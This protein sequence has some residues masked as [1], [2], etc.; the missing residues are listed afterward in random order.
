MDNNELI[1]CYNKGCGQKFKEE[2]NNDEVCK[3][4][5]GVPVFH[6]ALKGWSCCKKR[7]T[8]FTDFL[9]IPGCTTGPHNPVKPP[10]AEKSAIAP[11]KEGES[12]IVK[13]PPPPRARQK[14]I[15]ARPADDEPMV[16]LKTKVTSSLSSLLTR[17]ARQATVE[18]TKNDKENTSKESCD[19]ETVDIG[20]N[21]KNNGCGAV[22]VGV[23]S[24]ISRCQ[25][26]PGV[27][28]FHD[29]YKFWS[30]CQRR[31]SDFNE[32]QRQVGCATGDHL[33]IKPYAKA[34]ACRYDWYQ[35]GSFVVVSLFAK[36]CL[37]E[38]CSFEAN[39]T[40]LKLC[41]EY[42]NGNHCYEDTIKLHG[43]IDPDKS[44]VEL[45]GSK[46]DLKLRKADLFSWTSLKFR[47]AAETKDTKQV[48]S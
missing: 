47:D 25:H 30:C 20:T 43:V 35:M 31:T 21:C 46:V 3:Y 39:P 16:K 15:E 32:F 37:P 17:L 48:S 38:Q 34:Q 23:E 10:E 14:L 22:Y 19:M 41:L 11:L 33:W 28:I 18:V 26:H 5:P 7:S 27:A 1:Q 45:M 8:D 12:I 13:G 24:S 29:G 36:A 6:D 44:S 42:E 2:E 4:H 9:H 40:T